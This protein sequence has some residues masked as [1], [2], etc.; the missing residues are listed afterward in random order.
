MYTLYTYTVYTT[1]EIVNDM[2]TSMLKY[3]LLMFIVFIQIS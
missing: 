1:E 3:L 2:L